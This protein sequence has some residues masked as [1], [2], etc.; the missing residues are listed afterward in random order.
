MNFA[1]ITTKAHLINSTDPK[2]WTKM[3]INWEDGL[4]HF[5]RDNYTNAR[6]HL[7]ADQNE[8]RHGRSVL[9]TT[10]QTDECESF[11]VFSRVHNLNLYYQCQA[12]HYVIHNTFRFCLYSCP[13]STEWQLSWDMYRSSN[14]FGYIHGI[15]ISQN[16]W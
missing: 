10:W 2:E 15:I 14:S 11:E 3:E 13:P 7:T 8:T 16:D 1:D 6:I 4:L 5:T 12:K 9:V